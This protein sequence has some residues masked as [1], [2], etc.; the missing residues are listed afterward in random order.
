MDGTAACRICYDPA[1]KGAPLFAPCS[2]TGSV[3]WVHEQ[4][5]DAWRRR[6][7]NAMICQTCAR[8]YVLVETRRRLHAAC[9]RVR[10]AVD[11]FY[12]YRSQFDLVCIAFMLSLPLLHAAVY[13]IFGEI[14]P[15]FD[16]WGNSVAAAAYYLSVAIPGIVGTVG[17]MTTG[18]E[19]IFLRVAFPAIDKRRIAWS[20]SEGRHRA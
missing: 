7:G 6:P 1:E 13:L 17:L 14:L 3:R 19:A 5:L 16:R 15:H 12:K 4:C 20:G 8:P 10:S 2:C 18:L 9:R 11:T